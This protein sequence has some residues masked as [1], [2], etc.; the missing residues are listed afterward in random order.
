[1][2]AGH[3]RTQ[4]GGVVDLIQLLMAPSQHHPRQLV[5]RNATGR[6]PIGTGPPERLVVT[7]LCA[8][9][10]GWGRMIW[11]ADKGWVYATGCEAS[12][13]ARTGC[14]SPTGD[15]RGQCLCIPRRTLAEAAHPR[16]SRRGRGGKRWHDHPCVSILETDRC[17]QTVRLRGY[18][19]R[20]R[21][22]STRDGS[23]PRV[24]GRAR[25]LIPKQFNPA[26]RPDLTACGGF[27]G[28][29]RYQRRCMRNGARAVPLRHLR[30]PCRR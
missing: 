15:V 25:R 6:P 17:P 19:L 30:R 11:R 20:V 10:S 12:S 22:T 4:L 8:G 16:P 7:W 2:D 3:D 24:V 14:A 1:M 23:S 29:D 27:G 18:F 5:S 9:Y 13:P 26:I 21:P 28:C